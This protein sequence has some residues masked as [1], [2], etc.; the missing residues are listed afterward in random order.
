[1]N[2][3]ERGQ[4][5]ES[6]RKETW[7]RLSLG[8]CLLAMA[9]VWFFLSIWSFEERL[10]GSLALLVFSLLCLSVGYSAKKKMKQYEVK[11]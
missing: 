5:Y 3:F 8:Y 9:P 10:Y 11:K 7:D 6:A 1:M 2:E 4:L